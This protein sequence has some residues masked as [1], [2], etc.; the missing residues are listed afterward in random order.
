MWFIN[1]AFHRFK[2][3]TCFER[4]HVFGFTNIYTFEPNI[5]LIRLDLFSLISN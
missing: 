3:K 4:V 5:I 1:V 2:D